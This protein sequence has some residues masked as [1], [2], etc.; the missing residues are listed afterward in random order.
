[1]SL[2]GWFRDYLYIPIGGNRGGTAKALRNIL[3]VWFC[4]GF[5]HGASW[6]FILWG[7]YFFVLLLL[8]RPC[9]CVLEKIPNFIRI[10]FTFL[11]VLLGWTF[12]YITDI[13]RLTAVL[14]ILFGGADLY[15]DSVGITFMNNLPL[16]VACAIGSTPLPRYLGTYLE[17]LG[18]AED[19]RTAKRMQ[20]VCVVSVFIFE[21]AVLLFTTVSL[22][23]SSYNPFLYFRF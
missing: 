4:T 2:T 9:K 17:G 1:M 15:K 23:G 21:L 6:N 12:F 20:V 18:R 11:L 7:L 16:L 8:E 22:I 10:P 3:I 5:W 19:P 14:K 13:N